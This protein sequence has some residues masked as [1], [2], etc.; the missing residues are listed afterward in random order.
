MDDH[1][2]A[3]LIFSEHHPVDTMY[4][5][6]YNGFGVPGGYM[7]DIDQNQDFDNVQVRTEENDPSISYQGT[8]TTIIDQGA[9]GGSRNY[10][11]HPASFTFSFTG[12]SI[13]WINT[14]ALNRGISEVWIDGNL[15]TTVDLYDPNVLNQVVLYSNSS[16]SS[17]PHTIQ[18]K[19]TN[20]KNPASS[21]V[22]TSND[23]FDV[24]DIE[25]EYC[26]P[27][28]EANSLWW[29]DKKYDLGLFDTDTHTEYVTDV[30]EDGSNDIKDLVQE[31]ALLMAQTLTRL[32]QL[33]KV[34]NMESICS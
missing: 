16:L 33:S 1:L 17:G 11:D 7:P 34:S 15:M 8:W 14:K 25:H 5:K 19:S 22:L 13:K 26:A 21:G 29:L 18:I 20:T 10:A 24:D 6:D 31:L 32:E 27:V 28:A 4:W 3:Q 23:A 2:V 9:S 30:N 12:S